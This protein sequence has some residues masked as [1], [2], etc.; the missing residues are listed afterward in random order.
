MSSFDLSNR[1]E[2]A[3]HGRMIIGACAALG[4]AYG[5]Y[6]ASTGKTNG[7]PAW[8]VVLEDGALGVFIGLVV[9]IMAYLVLA[10][11][12]GKHDFKL[13]RRRQADEL[14]RDN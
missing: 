9:A 14:G 12:K 8:R 4:T 5:V 1:K 13:L 11:V 2:L 7:D 10:G 6:Q 3:Q